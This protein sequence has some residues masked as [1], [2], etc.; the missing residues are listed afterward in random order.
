M[1][2]LRDMLPDG[3]ELGKVFTGHGK[4]FTNEVRMPSKDWLNWRLID[5]LINSGDL[6]KYKSVLQKAKDMPIPKGQFFDVKAAKLV[7]NKVMK[8]LHKAMKIDPTKVKDLRSTINKYGE[9]KF[10]AEWNKY[11]TTK[12]VSG[13]YLY[14]LAASLMRAIADGSQVNRAIGLKESAKLVRILKESWL[15]VKERDWKKMTDEQK[16]EALLSVWDD[17]DKAERYW[18]Y[19]WR[20]LPSVATS[21]MGYNTKDY[22]KP[23]K[24]G[25]LSELNESGGYIESMNLPVMD[26]H[27]DGIKEL[28]LDW[29]NGPMTEKSDIKPAQKE[30]MSFIARWMKKNIK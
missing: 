22:G 29:K 25:K 3:A 17:A 24:K 4:A 23:G 19:K 14:S 5:V 15:D 21:N 9:D 20:E 6:N 13:N 30:L 1:P 10:T 16:I 8:P 2:K 7:F 12:E 26:K 28:W 11:Y 27:L 18:E